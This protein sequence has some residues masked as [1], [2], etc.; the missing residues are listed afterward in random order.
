[1]RNQPSWYKFKLTERPVLGPTTLDCELSFLMANMA[2]LKSGMLVLDPFCGTGGIL[3]A[4]TSRGCHCIGSDIDIRVLKGYGVGHLNKSW[5]G[6]NQQ[7]EQSKLILNSCNVLAN[8]DIFR[9]FDHYHLPRPDIIRLNIQ[10]LANY[11][12][13]QIYDAI[14]TD[15]PYGIRATC[16]KVDQ[17]TNN[18]SVGEVN[19][20][21]KCLLTLAERQL[22]CGGRLCFLLPCMSIDSEETLRALCEITPD[23]LHLKHAS[24]QN[25]SA[26]TGRLL[27]TMEKRDD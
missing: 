3:I 22:V 24:L 4:A 19:D 10:C 6:F 12:Y 2:K 16:R 1:M 26:G 17:Y 8:C 14:V 9:N 18:T 15:P 11:R 25:L 21:I 7:Q 20:L 27:V 23:C 5:S 13:R